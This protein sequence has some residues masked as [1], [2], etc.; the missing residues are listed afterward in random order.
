MSVEPVTEYTKPLPRPTWDSAAFWEACQQH[1]LELQFCTD[2]Q[3]FWFPPGNR[4]GHCWG[5]AWE[6]RPVSGRGQVFTF[7]IIHRAY[8]PG[9]GDDLPYN[10][11][12]VE[13]EEG[14]HLITNVVE[15]P[16]D[17]LRVGLPVS[18]VFDDVTAEATL[19]KFKP[20]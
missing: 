5:S 12:V 11:A 1:R 20:V 16:L 19:P 17:E 13:L 8:H 15:C 6:W 2:C 7:T 9:F 10:V 4:C 14:P 18:V 3:R